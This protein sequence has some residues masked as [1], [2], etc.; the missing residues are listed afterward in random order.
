MAT[1]TKKTIDTT[2]APIVKK[3]EVKE[4]NGSTASSDG[5]SC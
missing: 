1:N 3:E 4:V 5:T 2:S